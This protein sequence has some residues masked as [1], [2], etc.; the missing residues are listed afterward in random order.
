MVSRSCSP[1]SIVS[2]QLPQ[3]F[4]TWRTPTWK[5]RCRSLLL[6]FH[7]HFR[8][9]SCHH[10]QG[11]PSHSQVSTS[12]TCE[13]R[14]KQNQSRSHLAPAHPTQSPP[15]SRRRS[16]RTLRR[17][18]SRVRIKALRLSVLSDRLL[19]RCGRRLDRIGYELGA[20]GCV[21]CVLNTGSIALV[22]VMMDTPF[23]L[24]GDGVVWLGRWGVLDSVAERWNSVV[25]ITCSAGRG[26]MT[27]PSGS[28]A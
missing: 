17:D 19:Q 4:T 15:K 6:P 28:Y 11:C 10:Q 26:S 22:A 23:P 14:Q 1:Q 7:P 5:V 16:H 12:H 2:A 3:N 20:R 25:L 27:F 13:T 21:R 9:L 18:L 8:V 24:H